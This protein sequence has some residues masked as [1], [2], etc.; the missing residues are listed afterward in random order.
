MF[1]KEISIILLWRTNMII[2]RA[3]FRITLGGGG[4]D[5]PFYCSKFG[6][7]LLAAAINKYVYIIVEKRDFYDESFIRYSKTEIVKKH[8]DIQHTRIKAALEYL[9]IT[10][11]IEITAISD[12]PAKMGLGGSSTF[13]VALLKA[14]H[15][16]KREDI[17][18]KKLAEE[19]AHIEKEILG[20]PIGK[21]DQYLASFGGIKHLEIDKK[22]QVL[23]SPLNLS[24]SAVEELEN[25]L[26]LFSTGISHDAPDVLS[27]QAKQSESNEDKMNQMHIIRDVGEE[28]KKS[29][30]LGDVLK[31]GKWLNVDWEAKKRCTNKMS[32]SRIDRLCELGI[33]NGAIG[34]QLVG[35]GAGGFLLFYCQKNKDQLREA[36]NKE[37]LRELPFRFDNEGCKLLYE[38]R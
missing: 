31:F 35:A 11:P 2:A 25:N 28:I 19:A 9:D 13:L 14:L 4:T 38:G 27:D 23:V 10:D 37:G 12:V 17:S 21:Q 7:S 20:E 6:G 1:I 29:L 18:A 5:L 8:S 30:E 33:K 36:M 24:Y 26:L 3:P 32:S 34:G 15:I 22:E 16:Y